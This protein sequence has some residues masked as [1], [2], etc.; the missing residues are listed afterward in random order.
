MEPISRPGLTSSAA[1]STSP[2]SDYSSY[3][4]SFDVDNPRA[5]EARARVLQ[6]LGRTQEA[7]ASLQRALYLTQTEQES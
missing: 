3:Q 5:W 6:R 1:P 7:I 4:V 2:F